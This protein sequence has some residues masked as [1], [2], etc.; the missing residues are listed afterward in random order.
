LLLAVATGCDTGGAELPVATI[1][2]SAGIAIVE[3]V[4]PV[5]DTATVHHDTP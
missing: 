5:W 2:D 4:R 3:S 1:R